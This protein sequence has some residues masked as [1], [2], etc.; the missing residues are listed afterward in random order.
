MSDL[1]AIEV[2]PATSSRKKWREAVANA[3]AYEMKPYW[4]NLLKSHAG[5]REALARKMP[6]KQRLR[7]SAPQKPCGP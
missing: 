4:T 7:S 2:N 5:K 1:M 3:V 6:H